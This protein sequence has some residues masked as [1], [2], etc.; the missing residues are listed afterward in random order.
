VNSINGPTKLCEEHGTIMHALALAMKSARCWSDMLD[1]AEAMRSVEYDQFRPRFKEACWLSSD[2]APG[3]VYP[4]TME[5]ATEMIA[6]GG[7]EP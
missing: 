4:Q 6:G 7:N 3:A 2:R 1:I 5:Q